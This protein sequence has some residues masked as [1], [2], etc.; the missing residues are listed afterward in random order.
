MTTPWLAMPAV[1]IAICRGEAVTE[2]CPNPDSAVPASSSPAGYCEIPCSGYWSVARYRWLKPKPSA[3]LCMSVAPTLTASGA[4][5]V[6]QEYISATVRVI[7]SAQPGT[8]LCTTLLDCGSVYAGPAGTKELA[9]SP[10]YCTPAA[11]VRILNV[12]P[13]ASVVW[14]ARLSRGCDF[15]FDSREA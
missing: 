2:P 8:S 4:N 6:L 5:A 15:I 10:L 1:T 12:D 11:A 9:V 7:L 14:T 3:V 13:G